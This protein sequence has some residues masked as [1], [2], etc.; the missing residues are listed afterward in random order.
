VMMD[1]MIDGAEKRMD[2]MGWDGA[3]L[4]SL[5][6]AFPIDVPTYRPYRYCSGGTNI[7]EFAFNLSTASIFV[8]P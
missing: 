6:L 2:G 4:F 3:V 5:S 1:G 7:F 8:D